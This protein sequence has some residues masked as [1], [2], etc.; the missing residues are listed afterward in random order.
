MTETK[1]SM[2]ASV[3]RDLTA[4]LVVF[5]VALPL[6]LGVALASNAPLVSGLVAGIVGGIL[7][8]LLSGSQSSVSGPAAGLTAVVAAQILSLGSFEAFL[9]AVVF[10]GVLQIAMGIARGGSLAAFVPSSVI[11]GLLAAI[12][13]ILIYKQFA[14]VL[15]YHQTP[16]SFTEIAEAVSNLH[17]AAGIIGV[18]SVVF[19]VGWDKVKT[20]KKSPV[21]S[22]L[23]VVLIAVGLSLLFRR[24]GDEWTL[25]KKYLV[26]V[27]VAENPRDFFGLLFTPD[28]SQWRNPAV[29]VAAVTIAIVASLETLLNLQAV[30]KI[31]PRQRTSPPSR[32]LWAQGVGN[33]IC[34]LAGGLPITSVIVRSSVNINAGA[35]TKL[36][37]V[38]HGVL[39]FVC[40]LFFARQLNEIPLSCLAAILVVTGL[41]LASPALAKQMWAGGKYQ[42]A[43]FVITVV[44][45]VLTDLLI[46]VLIGMAVSLSFILWSNLRRPIRTIV[47]R[48]LGGDVVR[49]EL[50]NQ[51]SFLNRA[52]LAR[53]LDA[54]PEGGQLLLDASHTDYIDP[55]VL[56]LIRDFKNETGPARGI[57]VSL[58]GFRTKYELHDQIQYVDYSTRDLQEAVTPAQVLEILKAGHQRF[59]TGQQLTRDYGRQITAT[60]ESEHPLAVVLSCV[61][62]RTPAELIFDVG[63]GDIYS[64]RVAG[65]VTSRKVLG[66]IE[67]GCSIAG[68]KL[69]V[70][71]GHTRCGTVET[72][73]DL[74][75]TDDAVAASGSVNFSMIVAGLRKS[76]D[77][78]DARNWQELSKPAKTAFV[79]DV[80]TRNVARVVQ[81]VLT[82]SKTIADLTKSG[83]VAV[84]GAVYD[85]VTGNLEF[86]S[87]S[88]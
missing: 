44:A 34:G 22:A 80:T 30:D 68:A 50:A 77:P 59:R 5:L 72:A 47:E 10:A 83:Q 49:I 69:V 63:V 45:I 57:E 27:P 1:A 4:G 11:K 14:Y 75:A 61:D 56:A 15:G 35:R 8:G 51:V 24:F 43:P 39:L 79:D 6:C 13:V 41:K 18:F 86:L 33:V 70:V 19:L 40:V 25:G 7:V 62:S 55:D 37:A 9:L 28:F 52:A 21:P 29:Y 17:P 65:A 71:M 67:Y 32:E 78:L 64:V 20:L 85:V 66:S 76:I 36:S 88:S 60:A 84:V 26:D 46:G 48:H 2:V 42:F 38:F 53:H 74:L 31:D 87:A 16:K 12:G 23:L 58:L 54:V 3:P 81:S 73:I 82:D